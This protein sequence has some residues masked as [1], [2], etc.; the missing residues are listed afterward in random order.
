[1]KRYRVIISNQAKQSLR[2]IVQ[3]I[4]QDSPSAANY[5]RRV[6]IEL[7]KTLDQSPEK[8]G[9]EPLLAERKG[10]Y[11]SVTKW[12]YKIIYSVTA[13]DVIVLDI[14]HTSRNSKVIRNVR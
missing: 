8:H 10:N 7:I 11:R 4:S 14:I 5:V 3:Y 6:L 1:M 9:R 12:H 13:K 2:H